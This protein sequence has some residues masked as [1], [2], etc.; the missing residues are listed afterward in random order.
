MA[1]SV[2]LALGVFYAFRD[3][4]LPAGATPE[5]TS[6]WAIIYEHLPNIVASLRSL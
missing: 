1:A 3:I 5:S 2:I 6:L 4:L